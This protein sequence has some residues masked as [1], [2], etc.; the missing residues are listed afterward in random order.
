[1]Y[2]LNQTLLILGFISF[3]LPK[4]VGTLRKCACLNMPYVRSIERACVIDILKVRNSVLEN[5]SKRQK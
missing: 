5:I 4:I 2:A 3:F 1:M